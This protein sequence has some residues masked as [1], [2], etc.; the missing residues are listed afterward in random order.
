MQQNYANLSRDLGSSQVK[1]EARSQKNSQSQSHNQSQSYLCKFSLQVSDNTAIIKHLNLE[2]YKTTKC[3][4]DCENIKTCPYFHT[5]ADKRRSLEQAD[6]NPQICHFGINCLRKHKCPFAH[7]KYELK[8]HPLRYKKKYCKNLFD[9][10][11]CQ[12]A[13]F[14]ADAHFDEEL[15]CELLHYMDFDEDFMIFKYK[16]EF[17]PFNMEHNAQKCVYAHSWEDFR[18]NI[19]LFPYSNVACPHVDNHDDSMEIRCEAENDCQFAHGSYELEYHPLNYKRTK[20]TIEDCEGVFCPFAHK[21]EKKKFDR[22]AQLDNFY[23]YPYNRIL[24]GK[25][26]KSSSFF[27][28]ESENIIL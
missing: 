5:A 1:N 21:K 19:I 16:T 25:L 27:K 9:V 17:C 2:R 4:G 15:G 3:P 22:I 28:N 20:C 13:K 18:R 14:C 6:Y 11:K 7:N 8:Y 10:S 23:I 24:P 12:Y 26:V